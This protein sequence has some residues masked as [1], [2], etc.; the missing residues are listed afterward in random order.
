[1]PRQIAYNE[2]I[3]AKILSGVDKLANTVRSTLGPKG[4]NVVIH[5]APAPPL[6]T[7]DGA[8][9]A[10]EIELEDP[11][12]ELGAQLIRE[13]AAKINELAGDG[14]TTATILAQ[15]MIQEGIRNIAAGANPVEMKKGILS[16]AQLAAAAVKKLAVSVDSREMLVQVATVSAD[17]E[18]IG[19]LVADAMDQV[20][21]EGVITV[22]ESNSR[23]TILKVT[24]GMEFER[25]LLSSHFVTDPETVSCELDHPLILLTDREITS[26][27]ELASVLEAVAQEGRSLLIVAEKLEGDALATVVLNKISGKLK[28]AA[29]NPPAYAEGRRARMEDL[30]V[31]TGGVYI[32]EQTGHRLADAKLEWLGSAETVRITRQSTTIVNGAGDPATVA[33]KAQSL[34]TQIAR[35]DYDFDKQRLEER[36]AKFAS[37]VAVLQVGGITETEMKERKLRV[38]DAVHAVRAARAEG[39]VPGGGTALMHTI[40]AVEAY[41]KTLSGDQKTGA[42]IVLRALEAPLRQI[43]TNA[44]E[45]NSAVAARVKNSP[46]AVGYEAVSGQYVN[47]MDAGIIDPAR[48]TRL[49]LLTAASVSATMLTTEAGLTDSQSAN[50]ES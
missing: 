30:A 44:G 34:R 13:A 41:V 31:F 46:V 5:K 14:T 28:V 48:V 40:P 38:D 29:V 24:Q 39:V 6:V 12:E 21:P 17:S 26:A 50:L 49:A 8:T 27:H 20:G 18:S 3:R 2:E 10:K 25:G 9:I 36:L 32:T 45:D 1:M 22:E 4:R 47:M 15:C 7:N 42:R 33:A 16:A 37:G 23:D 19:Q 35:T 43:A 11:M